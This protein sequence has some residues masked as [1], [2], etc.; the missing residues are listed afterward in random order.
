MKRF[1]GLIIATIITVAINAQSHM[2][3]HHKGGWHS[4]VKIEQIDSVTFV[5]G[6]D[7][8]TAEE[9]LIGSWFWGNTDAGYYEVLTF[10]KDRTYIASDY[11]MDY[12]FDTW[13]Y[14]TY[15]ANGVFLN[16][17]SNGYGYRRIYRWFVTALTGNALEV[18]TQMGSFTYYRVQSEVYSLGIGEESYACTGDDKYVFTDG[19]NVTEVDGK[20]KGISEG[21]TYI[22]KYNATLGLIIAYKVI[23]GQ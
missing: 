15:M 7:V 20:L 12:R 2:R 11:Y 1:F 3:I 18:M 4:D 17:L 21:A 10:N 23:V 8:P 19:V 6:S 22:L 14:G 9:S 16:L 13:T 5:D